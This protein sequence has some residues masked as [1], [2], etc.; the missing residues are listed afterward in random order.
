M[1]I[2]FRLF[3]CGDSGSD[4]SHWLRRDDNMAARDDWSRDLLNEFRQD[5]LA[6]RDAVA[7][8]NNSP[9]RTSSVPPSPSNMYAVY[10]IFRY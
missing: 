5:V 4:R 1:D 2:Y 7:S 9:N 10:M 6:A 3:A 8:N